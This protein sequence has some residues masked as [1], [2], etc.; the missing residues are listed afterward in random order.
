MS[1]KD[2]SSKVA[3]LVAESVTCNGNGIK[4]V[5][6]NQGK[7]FAYFENL[8]EVRKDFSKRYPNMTK[9][10]MYRE[11]LKPYKHSISFEVDPDTGEK[12]EIYKCDYGSCSKKFNK[13]WNLVDHLRMHEGIRPYYCEYCDKYFTQKGNLQKHLKQHE[14]Q[15]VNQRK[16][17]KCDI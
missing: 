8:E 1:G 11:L 17:F 10:Q 5:R 16:K 9:H 4:M 7:Q 3:N 15:N 13:T 2:T 6:N 12:K 14:V